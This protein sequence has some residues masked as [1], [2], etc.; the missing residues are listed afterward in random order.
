MV[1]RVRPL[2]RRRSYDMALSAVAQ[3]VVLRV[4]TAELNEKRK[5][6]AAARKAR[7]GQ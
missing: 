7:R 5:A 6:K 2:R 1:L 4:I 3:L